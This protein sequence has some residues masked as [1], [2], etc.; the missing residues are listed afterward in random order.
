MS[1]IAARIHMPGAEKVIAAKVRLPRTG[2]GIKIAINVRVNSGKN[3][4]SV[5]LLRNLD[6]KVPEGIDAS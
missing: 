6:A 3:I 1:L 4:R 2:I 5:M